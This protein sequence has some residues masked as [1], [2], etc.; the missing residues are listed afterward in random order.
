MD[1]KGIKTDFDSNPPVEVSRYDESIRL[2][3][4]AYEPLFV[5]LAI[6]R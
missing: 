2:F 3:C 1:M 6:K 5:T 4:A